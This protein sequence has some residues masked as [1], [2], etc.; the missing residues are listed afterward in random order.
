LRAT[1]HGAREVALSNP[2]K[3][4]LIVEA[5]V[6]IY[7]VGARTIAALL[8]ANTL[9]IRY[10]PGEELRSQRELLRRRLNLVKIRI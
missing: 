4:R 8:R 7:K 9:P 1:N 2:A 10:V 5:K 3:T 6:K